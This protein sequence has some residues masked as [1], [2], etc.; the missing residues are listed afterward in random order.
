MAVSPKRMR[1]WSRIRLVPLSSLG[2]LKGGRRP[3][4]SAALLS[5][6]RCQTRRRIPADRLPLRIPMTWL[7]RILCR[8]GPRSVRRPLRR[9]SAAGTEATR[10]PAARGGKGP[11]RQPPSAPAS[12]G[13][14]HLP[15]DPRRFAV[16]TATGR[17][18]ARQVQWPHRVAMEPCG[19]SSEIGL[20]ETGSP[21]PPSLAAQHVGGPCSTSPTLRTHGALGWT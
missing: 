11:G 14:Q 2:L 10:A 12:S 20:P 6:R 8:A 15:R 5:R 21:I 7:S 17:R 19:A 13:V 16:D 18:G 1:I 3:P 4:R 9:A